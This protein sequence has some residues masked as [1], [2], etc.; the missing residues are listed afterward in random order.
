MGVFQS[1]QKIYD[2]R[3]DSVHSI[4][5]P[6]SGPEEMDKIPEVKLA[7]I[8]KFGEEGDRCCSRESTDQYAAL[9]RSGKIAARTKL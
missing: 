2:R 6:C 7:I 3:S 8:S 1:V 4:V 5:N 9:V